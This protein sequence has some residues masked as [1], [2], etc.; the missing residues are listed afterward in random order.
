MKSIKTFEEFS[1]DLKNKSIEED[2]VTAGE[3]SKVII[4]DLTLDSGKKIKSTEILGA[5][6]NSKTEK[7]FKDYFYDEYGNGAFTDEDISTLLKSYLEYTEEKNAKETEEEEAEKEE[8][9][10]GDDELE[11]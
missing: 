1:S 2:A 7:E 8:E 3:E 5:V 4:D 6:I 10:G 9:E 11:I